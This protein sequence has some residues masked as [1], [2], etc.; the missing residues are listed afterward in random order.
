LAAFQVDYE[1]TGDSSGYQDDPLRMEAWKGSVNAAV[2]VMR[3]SGA[4]HVSLVGMRLGANLAASVCEVCRPDELVLWDPCD[5][6]RAYLHEQDVFRALYEASR[7]GP[8]TAPSAGA[9]PRG[10][11]QVEVLGAV[12]GPETV[13]AVRQLGI[14]PTPVA[15]AGHILALLRPEKAPARAVQAQLLASGAELAD[16]VGQDATLGLWRS[17]LFVP[18]STISTIVEWLSR[19]AGPERVPMNVPVLG[20]AYIPARKGGGVVE[21]VVHFGPNHLFGIVTRSG[22]GPFAL[23]AVLLNS[24]TVDHAGPGR[25]WVEVARSWAG[26]GLQVVRFDSSGIGDSQP[27]ADRPPDVVYGPEALEDVAEVVKAVSPGH[28][29]E[30]VLAGLCSG[31]YHSLRLG[32]EL[33]VGG[34]LA[35]NPVFWGRSRGPVA[36]GWVHE[37]ACGPHPAVGATTGQ[38]R[39]FAHRMLR[40]ADNRFNAVTRH[41]PDEMR[42]WFIKRTGMWQ[43]P[44][45]VLKR[46]VH[47]GVDTF[48][49]CGRSEA[50]AL[51]R[52]ERATFRRLESRRGFQM[53]VLPGIDHSLL[54][55]A[56]RDQVL[57]DLTEHVVALAHNTTKARAPS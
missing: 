16:A 40:S 6:G 13:Q 37:R 25:L 23:T 55:Q 57:H 39:A 28:C 46:L 19:A 8:A 38:P 50:M 42:W 11:S 35:V 45:P 54:I 32:A 31:A 26:T 53:E 44:A 21:E 4:R 41:L 33:G 52:G 43:R 5:S 30:V 47:R 3:T 2:D 12:Y 48:V 7:Y 27:R 22:S 20:T 14:G 1:G 17:Q 49:V 29:S 36:P 9:P 15:L 51:C 56:A 18:Q 34:V 10:Q 24:G